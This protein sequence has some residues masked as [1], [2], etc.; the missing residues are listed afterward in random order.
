MEDL[1]RHFAV[2]GNATRNIAEAERLN[3]SLHY[4]SKITMSL[5][6]FLTQCQKIFNIYKK[7][8]K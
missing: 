6:I 7:E 5:E 1:R 4:K 8:E 2:E 3:E